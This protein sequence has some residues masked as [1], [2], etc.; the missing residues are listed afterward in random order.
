MT[1][2]LDGPRR[3]PQQLPVRQLVVLLHGYGADGNDP[4]GLA[5]PWGEQV[6]QALFLS[7][8]A[9][10]PCAIS[11]RGRE[12][13]PLGSG[14]LR[15]AEDVAADLREGV[16]AAADALN[17]Y[18]DRELAAVNLDDRALALVGFSQGAAV[19][20]HVGLRRPVAAILA[21]SGAMGPAPDRKSTR[22][23]S[24]HT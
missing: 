3:G 9:P 1:S 13:F 2:A 16:A 12:W 24:S 18:L 14:P 8:H 11:P 4:I 6:P 20:L 7:P 17:A 15:T 5:D 19:A 23:N 10:R 22:L 21:Y